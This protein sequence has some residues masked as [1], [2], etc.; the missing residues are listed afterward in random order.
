LAGHR[1]STFAATPLPCGLAEAAARRPLPGASAVD[2][3]RFASQIDSN[4]SPPCPVES[5]APDSAT[6]WQRLPKSSSLHHAMVCKIFGSNLTKMFRDLGA[7]ADACWGE[8]PVILFCRSGLAASMARRRI[9]QEF[10]RETRAANAPDRFVPADGLWPL[11]KAAKGLRRRPFRCR[12]AALSDRASFLRFCGFARD[13]ATPERTAF[14][15][16]RRR[17]AAHGRDQ[18][19]FASDSLCG[20]C[21]RS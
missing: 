5:M 7:D 9:G 21:P 19:L 20:G 1:L 14:A 10:W 18:T 3:P 11:S 17:L 2:R 4:G 13:E 8:R 6:H 12:A 16:F 15:R